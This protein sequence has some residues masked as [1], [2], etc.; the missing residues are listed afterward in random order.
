MTLIS[1]STMNPNET[2]TLGKV[3]RLTVVIHHFGC[4]SIGMLRRTNWKPVEFHK[5]IPRNR[6]LQFHDFFSC[7]STSTK[8]CC[9][10]WS[11]IFCLSSTYAGHVRV[12]IFLVAENK[13]R[14]SDTEIRRTRGWSLAKQDTCKH[15][16]SHQTNFEIKNKTR[17]RAA[18]IFRLIAW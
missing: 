1:I 10:H 12:L 6:H 3:T 2:A 18:N 9:R 15:S 14:Q 16:S 17:R 8:N 11:F 7:L 13:K 5:V 4:I